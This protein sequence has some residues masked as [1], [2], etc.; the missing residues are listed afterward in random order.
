MFYFKKFQKAGG[1]I[2][3]NILTSFLKEI[4][5]AWLK[6]RFNDYNFIYKSTKTW[7]SNDP[8]IT[9]RYYFSHLVVPEN[10]T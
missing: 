2:H 3:L 8:F 1:P 6:V 7:R 10:N 4:E 5:I 9:Q